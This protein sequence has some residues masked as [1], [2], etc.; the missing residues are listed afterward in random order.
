VPEGAVIVE[1]V[2]EAPEGD[3]G[4]LAARMEE[5]LAK[6]D[7]SQPTKDRTA[8]STFRNPAGFSSTGRAD[9]TH[10]MKAWKLI[11]D[12]GMRGARRGGALMNPMHA[13]FLTNA[14]GATAAEL[15]ELGEAV[16]KAVYD[17]AGVRLEW[18]I[19]RVGDPA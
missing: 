5:Q 10:E 13:N 18:E 4:V 9:D 19:M 11:D 12:A 6:R 16:R 8:G 17:H 2:F 14:G 1:A 7:A 15:E 3:P